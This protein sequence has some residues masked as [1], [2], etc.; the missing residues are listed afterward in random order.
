M[1]TKLK[2]TPAVKKSSYTVSPRNNIITQ[3]LAES[4]FLIMRNRKKHDSEASVSMCCLALD[5]CFA[6]LTIE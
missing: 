1:A 3:K 5:L 6:L 2:H 4:H